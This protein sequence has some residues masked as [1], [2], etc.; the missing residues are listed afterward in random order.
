MIADRLFEAFRYEPSTPPSRTSG[1]A[2]RRDRPSGTVTRKVLTTRTFGPCWS[3]SI[4]APLVMLA[5][6]R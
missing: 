3:A 2:S 4:A 6:R 5:R 1:A